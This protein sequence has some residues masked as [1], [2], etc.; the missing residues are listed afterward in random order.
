[1][2]VAESWCL[3]GQDWKLDEVSHLFSPAVDRAHSI[4]PVQT[5]CLGTSQEG[6]QQFPLFILQ[7]EKDSSLTSIIFFDKHY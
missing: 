2:S 3:S 6:S 4:S 5:P 1:M 7:P